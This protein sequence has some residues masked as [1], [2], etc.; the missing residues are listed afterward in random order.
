M[1]RF[2][3][4]DRSSRVCT[5]GRMLIPILAG[6]NKKD[7]SEVF[8]YMEIFPMEERGSLCYFAAFQKYDLFWVP[9][10][11]YLQVK[12][13][14]ELQEIPKTYDWTTHLK[15]SSQTLLHTISLF[16]F[17]FGRRR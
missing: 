7:Q 6:D 11:S 10:S 14:T 3:E 4:S 16:T 13:E 5:I 8:S 2:S 9:V 12:V 15:G 17:S 1:T